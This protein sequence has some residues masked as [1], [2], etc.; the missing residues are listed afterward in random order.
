MPVTKRRFSVTGLPSPHASRFSIRHRLPGFDLMLENGDGIAAHDAVAEIAVAVA[1]AGA[2]SAIVTHHRAGIAS[3]LLAGGLFRCIGWFETLGEF[4]HPACRASSMAASTRSG[5]AGQAGDGRAGGVPDGV[6]G[7]P[8]RS[9][10]ATCSPSPLAPNGPSGSGT[11]TRIE[12]ICG[13]S[14]MV[15]IR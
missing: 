6:E 14:P 5:V 11:S 7:S 4:A 3:E 10:S 12:W 9:G 8:G 2:A 1:G 15:G 13:T